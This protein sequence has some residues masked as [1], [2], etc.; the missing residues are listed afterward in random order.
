MERARSSRPICTGRIGS[1]PAGAAT[2]NFPLIFYLGKSGGYLQKKYTIAGVA[3]MLV[4]GTIVW[5]MQN[6]VPELE[7]TSERGSR[8]AS[9]L[10]FRGDPSGPGFV[11]RETCIQCHAEEGA[12]FAGSDHDRAM[13]PANDSTVSGNFDDDSL[14]HHGMVSRFYRRD[15]KFLVS[16]EGPDGSPAE[17]E[18]KYTFGVRPLQQYLVEFP[19]G[20]LQALST[21]WD[22]EKRQWFHLYPHVKFAPD[23]WLHWTR[24]AQNW[25]GMCA[26]CHSTG[27]KRGYDIAS[28]TFASSWSEID[29][30]CEACHG[31]GSRHVN[32][33]EGAALARW[34]SGD[35]PENKYGL[36]ADYTGDASRAGAQAEV[37]GCAECHSRRSSLQPE[38]GHLKEFMDKFSL[39][40]L[41]PNTY[42]ADGQIDDEVFEYGSFLQS[43]MYHEGVKCSDCHDPH[44]LNLR[45]PG[46]ALCAQC[47]EPARFDVIS[48]HRHPVDSEG[49]K[50]VDCHMPSKNYM[51]IDPRRDHSF[52]IPRPD[53]SVQ[54]GT[55]NACMQ[56][57]A[58]RPASWAADWV[59]KWHG[60]TRKPHFSELLAKGRSGEPGAD[61]ALAKLAEHPGHPAIAR[62][63]ALVLLSNYMGELTRSAL[64][65]GAKDAEPMVRQAAASGWQALPEPDRL[66]ALTPL[67][68]DSL[69]AV[70]IQAAEALVSSSARLPDSSRP[71]YLKA[72]REYRISLDANAYFPGGRFN[73]G[74]YHERMGNPDSA[75]HAYSVA[76]DLDNRFVQARN[77]LALLL[78]RL[79]RPEEAAHHFRE[80][81]RLVPDF[82]EAYYSLGLLLAAQGRND[83]AA[84]YLEQAAQ[85]IPGNARIH[86]NLG[87]ILQKLGRAEGAEAA[88]KQAVK[89]SGM[90]PDFLYALAWFYS[91]IGNWDDAWRT[92]LLLGKKSP[93]Y[94][95]LHGLLREISQRRVQR[96]GS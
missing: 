76:L 36:V 13:M 46:N 40:L 67:L 61:S 54:F 73:L 5:R 66:N 94:P 81:I 33:A 53:L 3:V 92:A 32:W 21:S 64:L 1:G 63:S 14:V 22:V 19:G 88:L 95:G 89:V 39:Q 50:C 29:V 25:N 45:A 12:A 47:H 80:S 83:S 48:H 58:D 52:R 17:F 8:P 90:N 42:H 2:G 24:D 44:S 35:G 11:G 16:T 18:I 27:F 51:Q 49:S 62:A 78:D 87:L 77:N 20:R 65:S 59:E 70:R 9:W 31:P 37:M 69:R 84:H 55:P 30:S 91:T 6:P 93:Q 28:G 96:P 85:R 26:D 38:F 10:P 72:L 41:L 82:T 71:D 68:R 56:C 23:D 75:V 15:G 79:G 60:P 4:L 74:Q 86:Y 43:K 7:S 57:H 34:I